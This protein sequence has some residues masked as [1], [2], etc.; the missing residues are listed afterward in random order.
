MIDVNVPESAPESLPEGVP[1]VLAY[2]WQSNMHTCP[3]LT[4]GEP[5]LEPE[6][7][8]FSK[9][10]IAVEH[11]TLMRQDRD[12]ER[13]L[14]REMSVR[15]H[16]LK[17]EVK[18]FDQLKVRCAQLEADAAKWKIVQNCM[19]QLGSDEREASIWT[20]C[21]QLLISS[22]HLMNSDTSTVKQ[23]CVTYQGQEIGDWVVTVQ[24]ISPPK[25][26]S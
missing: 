5:D 19:D 20:A 16:E 10:L 6:K 8:S 7:L 14:R 24:K 26:A 12:S 9:P 1:E 15:I 18:D 17:D 2:H 23:E 3:D 4:R 11:Y 25:E 21:S 22:A 13:Q